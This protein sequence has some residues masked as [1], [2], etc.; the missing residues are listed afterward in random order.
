M[1]E[2]FLLDLPK[3]RRWQLWGLGFWTT[4]RGAG[5]F[6]LPLCLQR[7]AF[8]IALSSTWSWIWEFHAMRDWY[9]KFNLARLEAS[10]DLSLVG[11]FSISN[12]PGAPQGR[13]R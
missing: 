4:W 5:P 7:P 2:G 3:S 11:L 9:H 1:K 13:R 6:R 10:D 8:Y 12:S